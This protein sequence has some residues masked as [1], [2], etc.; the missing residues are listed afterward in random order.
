MDN[1]REVKSIIEGLLFAWG[2]PLEIKDLSSVLDI[3]VSELES[4]LKEMIDDFNY[5]RRGL[6]IIKFNNSYQIGT[7]PEHYEWISKLN[8]DKY[9]KNLSN[10]SLETLSIIAYKQPIIK[11]DIESIRGVK[12]DRALDT[13]MK[14][15]LI[16]EMG[17]L[18]R[19][20][21][22]IL[23]STTDEFLKYFGLEN[24]KDL[25]HLSELNPFEEK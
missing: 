18:E 25:P 16:K 24:L 13:L 5:N 21:R 1:A 9:K 2:D 20:G 4:I 23:Y 15:N 22:P 11:S 14:K 8:Q 6:R 17:R 3:E 7:R 12:C 19:A 10:A